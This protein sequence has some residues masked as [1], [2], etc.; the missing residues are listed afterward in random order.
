MTHIL[1][2][3]VENQQGVLARISGL[4]SGRGYNVESITA[5]PTT[6]PTR[7]ADHPRLYGR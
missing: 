2:L 4:L 3:L 7:D 6:D 1:S 5:G